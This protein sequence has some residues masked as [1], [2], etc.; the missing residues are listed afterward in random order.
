MYIEIISM[1]LILSF[2]LMIVSALKIKESFC[3]KDDVIIKYGDEEKCFQKGSYA[4]ITHMFPEKKQCLIK[5]GF[6]KLDV[7]AD[8]NLN[9]YLYSL[10]A[11][12]NTYVMC[13]PGSI[14]VS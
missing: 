5:T 6:N 1:F 2:L 13:K 12:Y 9:T 11:E 14:R 8:T 7:Y 4:N 3:T 10:P